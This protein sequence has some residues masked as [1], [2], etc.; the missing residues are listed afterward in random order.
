MSEIFTKAILCADQFKFLIAQTSDEMEVYKN[1]EHGIEDIV[2][3]SLKYRRA[4]ISTVDARET[5]KLWL[6]HVTIFP[7]INDP[8]PIYG[9][10]IVAG[11]TKVSGAFHDFS[12]SG[13]PD[14]TMMKWFADHTANLDWNKKRE[15]PEWAKNIFSDSM[16]AIGA[17]GAE[18]LDKFVEVGISSLKYYL[19]QVGISQQDVAT[20]DM[21]QNRYCHYQKQN[22]H[23]PNVLV[24]LGLSETEARNFVAER[25]FPEIR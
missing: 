17:V 3:S 19:K 11:P 4:H 16:V 5:R 8:S 9:F 21:A 13:E 2:F 20:Y 7:Q 15:L 1:P 23:T 24:K 18:E 12:S 14:H 10:D 25:L 6:L 22:P